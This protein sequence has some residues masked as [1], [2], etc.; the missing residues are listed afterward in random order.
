MSNPKEDPTLPDFVIIGA[1]KCGTTT[2]AAQFS[3]QSGVFITTPKEPNFFSDDEIY[4]K[5]EDWYRRLF[6][7]AKPSDLKGEASTHY[8]KLPTHPNSV[9]RM[10]ELIPQAK[11]IYMIRNPLARAVSHYIHE[12]SLRNVGSDWD[13]ALRDNPSFTEYGCYGMQITPFV[14]AYGRDKVFL[15]SLEAIKTDP[16]SEFRKI[17]NFLGLPASIQWTEDL[18]SQNVS[19]DRFR[20][21]PLQSVLV[22]NPIA[23]T[24]RR[25]LIPKSVRNKIRSGRRMTRRPELPDDVKARM[26]QIF[27]QDREVLATHFP[28]HATLDLCYPFREQ[29]KD[30]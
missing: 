27:L 23:R 20:R 28:D 25:V 2:L 9:A 19:E 16:K 1:M 3:A 8:T 10:K 4:A 15:T 11:L 24:L 29:L 18:G 13:A 17:S 22:D 6:R 21:L 14:E 5:G 7:E 12:W 30:D 26:V